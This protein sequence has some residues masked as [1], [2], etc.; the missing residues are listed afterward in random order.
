[1]AKTA[2]DAADALT[3]F[4]A[5]ESAEPDAVKKVRPPTPEP[6]APPRPPV[7]ATR[8]APLA[9]AEGSPP[10]KSARPARP[11]RKTTPFAKATPPVNLPL[12]LASRPSSPRPSPAARARPDSEAPPVGSTDSA[13]PEPTNAR[14]VNTAAPSRPRSHRMGNVPAREPANVR[15]A[16]TTIPTCLVLTTLLPVLAVAWLLLPAAS[17]LKVGGGWV[18]PVLFAFALACGVAAW[19]LMRQVARHHA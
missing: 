15:A 4:A 13:R 6:A 3:A 10:A 19:T 7:A 8:P 1:M 18:V 12:P 16:R 2:Q 5:G 9:A 17:P 14:E 11:T